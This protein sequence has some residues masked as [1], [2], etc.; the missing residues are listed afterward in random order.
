MIAAGLNA[1]RAWFSV[2]QP[3]R[4]RAYL[5]LSVFIGYWAPLSWMRYG[6]ALAG[7]LSVSQRLPIIA[8]SVLFNFLPAALLVASLV[9]ATLWMI[10]KLPFLSQ[11]KQ[12][13]LHH[14]ISTFVLALF[15][16]IATLM[17]FKP[18]VLGATSHLFRLFFWSMPLLGAFWIAWEGI[19]IARWMLVPR[20]LCPCILFFSALSFTFYMAAPAPLQPSSDQQPRSSAAHPNVILITIDTLSA[21]HLH[22][23]GYQLPTSPNLDQFASDSILFENS[24]ANANWTRPGIASILNGARPWTHRADQGAPLPHV[25]ATQNLATTLVRSGYVFLT[26]NHDGFAGTYWQGIADEET[27]VLHGNPVLENRIA[28]FWNLFFLARQL[29]PTKFVEQAEW[30]F[31]EWFNLSHKTVDYVPRFDQLLRRKPVDHPTFYWVHLMTPHDPYATIPPFL[32]M[33]EA[34]PLARTSSTSLAQY[35]FYADRNPQRQQLLRGRYDEAVTMSDAIVGGL[36]ASLKQQNLYESSL[37]VI[38]SDHGE[39]FIPQYGGHGGPLLREEVIRVPLLIK[40]PY[41]HGSKRE[42]LLMEQ[43][44]IVP[45]ILSYAGL[46]IPDGME[47]QA[48]PGKPA[49]VPVFSINHDLQEDEHSL[50]VAMRDRDW[51]YV[52]HLGKWAHPWPRQEL[53]N[54]A[55]DPRENINLTD[56]YPRLAETM[57]Q[58]VLHE[59]DAHN[60]DVKQYAR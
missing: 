46:P 24:Y 11:Q 40:P 17:V 21:L 5:L 42:S 16:L 33:F 7:N 26:D 10:G 57:R 12:Q 59:L 30:H 29:G 45:T 13:K 3:H 41:F 25:I 51:K 50:S 56:K 35:L 60:V 22:S 27:T 18:S 43:A 4:S 38:T 37:I 14:F 23:Y 39:N 44:D 2:I 52:L 53:Y 32:G 58:Q 28:R 15:I 34:S 48:Y 47:G 31:Y 55:L 8:A 36:I 54:L 19:S 6:G 9:H 1:F 49:Q 20:L